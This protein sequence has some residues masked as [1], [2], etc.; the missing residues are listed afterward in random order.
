MA[1]DG[2]RWIEAFFASGDAD[3][4]AVERFLGDLP[5]YCA[6]YGVRLEVAS[7]DDSKH[8]TPALLDA[9]ASL[10]ARMGGRTLAEQYM[11]LEQMVTDAQPAAMT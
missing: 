4:Q 6:K 11:M 1:E 10:L 3:Q 7:V 9:A 2:G 8:A 5:D